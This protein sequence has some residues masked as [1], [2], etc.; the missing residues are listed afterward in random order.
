MSQNEP[1]IKKELFETIQTT[2]FCYPDL[3][4][5]QQIA[6]AIKPKIFHVEDSD[7]L[8]HLWQWIT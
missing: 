1:N 5:T 4:L 3:M 8:K 7:F 6:N 2:W